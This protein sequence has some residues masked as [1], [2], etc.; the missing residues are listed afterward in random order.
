MKTKILKGKHVAHVEGV[1]P[2]T[3]EALKGIG[4]CSA[5]NSEYLGGD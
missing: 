5:S 1:E 4:Q 3:P 2:K